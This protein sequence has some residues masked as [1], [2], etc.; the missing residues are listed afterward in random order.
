MG[1]ALG[2]LSR[3]QLLDDHSVIVAPRHEL[4]GARVANTLTAPA[5]RF[6]HARAAAVLLD[7]PPGTLTTDTF[8]AAADHFRS[9]GDARRA[10][11]VLTE[12]AAAV[13]R[14]GATTD[15]IRLLERAL[16]LDPSAG[17]RIS[18]L[19]RLSRCLAL[20]GQWPRVC[21]LTADLL[22]LAAREP[23]AAARAA[24]ALLGINAQYRRGDDPSRLLR[25]AYCL[26]SDQSLSASMRVAAARTGMIIASNYGTT[27]DQW[28]LL[29]AISESRADPAIDALEIGTLDVIFETNVGD[30]AVGLRRADALRTLASRESDP[31]R[32]LTAVLNAAEAHLAAG[33]VDDALPLFE[34]VRG[35][36]QKFG[37]SY[38]EAIAT[39]RITST[40]IEAGHAQSGR[41][42]LTRLTHCVTH[43]QDGFHEA[44]MKSDAARLA[45][46]EGRADDAVA[47]SASLHKAAWAERFPMLRIVR[48][49]TT[50]LVEAL[51]CRSGEPIS[52]E[53]VDELERLHSA[54]RQY[55]HHDRTVAV[56][57][58]ALRRNG[59][60]RI[61]EALLD[62]YIRF[63]RRS[64]VP[65]RDPLEVVRARFRRVSGN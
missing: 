24:D 38:Y 9:A 12:S 36:A 28:L 14:L 29:D 56:L 61:A 46:L 19:R 63:H 51:L 52:N 4:V 50:V 5:L 22:T 13:Q 42:W 16:L 6:H 26:A 31:A 18:L 25:H 27:A 65:W 54:T 62:K 49:A 59:R 35:E 41:E 30:M 20:N 15:S 40:L 53:L 47:I 33:L 37:S 39:H 11:Q 64:L 3:E 1:P 55:L 48:G 10:I 34:E 17:E 2:E 7:A 32:K 45:V 57:T 58:L 8:L 21:E 44:S 23:D 60:D 43:V